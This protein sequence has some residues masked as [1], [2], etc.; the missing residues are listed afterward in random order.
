MRELGVCQGASKCIV[1]VLACIIIFICSRQH[2]V[3]SIS[4][5]ESLTT[6]SQDILRSEVDFGSNCGH[7]NSAR[8]DLSKTRKVR[9][10]FD[11]YSNDD[12][13]QFTGRRVLVKS[14]N[15]VDKLQNEELAKSKTVYGKQRIAKRR[16]LSSSKPRLTRQNSMTTKLIITSNDDDDDKTTNDGKD[17]EDDELC[18]KISTPN[19]ISPRSKSLVTGLSVGS[20]SNSSTPTTASPKVK[21]KKIEKTIELA[22]FIDQALDSKFA[23]LSGGFVELKKQVL[24]IMSQVSFLDLFLCWKSI[25]D[26]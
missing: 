5:H 24:S 25:I 11:R 2:S 1:I 10:A 23:G 14:G 22:V 17:N 3:Y 19:K 4:R 8:V 9:S 16:N 12:D 6:S 13:G 18:I 20:N 21:D 26:R 15:V 7:L